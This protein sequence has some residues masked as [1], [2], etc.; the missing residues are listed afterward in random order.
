MLSSYN[1]LLLLRYLLCWFH[2]FIFLVKINNYFVILVIQIWLS[3]KPRDIGLITE[4]LN[5][6]ELFQ[7]FIVISQNFLFGPWPQWILFLWHFA[8]SGSFSFVQKFWYSRVKVF[9]RDTTLLRLGFFPLLTQFVSHW[10]CFSCLNI[11]RHFCSEFCEL[12]GLIRLVVFIFQTGP[13]LL[14][15]LQ[16]DCKLGVLDRFK[17]VQD[18]SC[19]CKVEWHN[20]VGRGST[21]FRK[22]LAKFD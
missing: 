2:L 8:S 10:R 9:C 5:L 21:V 17:R 11:L 20:K 16:L 18:F 3:S 6:L 7:H 4:R 19:S 15:L 13:S 12:I 22:L 1:L 14:G